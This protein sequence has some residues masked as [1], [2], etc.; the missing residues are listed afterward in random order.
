[1]T[2]P[3]PMSTSSAG[4]LALAERCEQA[5]GPDRELDALVYI[6]TSFPTWR[7][8]TDCEPFPDAVE[9]GRIQGGDSFSW[10][11]SPAFTASLDAAMTLVPEGAIWEVGHKFHYPRPP[12]SP[13][14]A[15]YA[16]VNVGKPGAVKSF[17]GKSVASPAVAL[18][19]AAL[20]ARASQEQQQ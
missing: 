1:M 4:L 6:A 17:G 3:Q 9:V 7:L 11:E 10:R 20:R 16:F 18:C 5:T 13:D 15:N 12:Q 2:D 8:Q 14:R 19:A